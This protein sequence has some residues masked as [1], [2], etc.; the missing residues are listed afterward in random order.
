MDITSGLILAFAY[1]AAPGPITIETLRQGIKGGFL[2]SLAVQSG[3]AI[4]LMAY[5]GL[6]LLG[7][8][9]APQDATWQLA[10]GVPGMTLLFYLGITTIRS[11]RN[12]AVPP[13]E[14][15]PGGTSARRAFW[16]GAGLSLANPLDILFWLSMGSRI[17][18]DP[19]LAGPAFLAG[20]FAGCILTALGL[21]IFA[22]FWQARLP[23]K[24]TLAV[25]WIC[26][27]A[28]IGFGLRMGLSLAR[29]LIT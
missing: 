27:L 8:R 25:S 17:S 9:L 23:S 11:G 12:L 3:S 21:A 19:R 20:F 5:A 24:A 6:A 4:G 26:G 15:L 7:A 14:R 18:S 29:T 10:A 2:H 22:S 13:G 28:L 16:T 1:V